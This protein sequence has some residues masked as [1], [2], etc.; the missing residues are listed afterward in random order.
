MLY[1]FG[2]MYLWEIVPVKLV[3]ACALF[4][5]IGGGAAVS[6][7]M[8]YAMGSDITTDANRYDHS[9]FEFK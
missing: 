6:T 7:M 2:I 9:R 5:L 3:W 1:S 8:L 4:E